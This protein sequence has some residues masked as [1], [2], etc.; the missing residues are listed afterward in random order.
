MATKGRM[1]LIITTADVLRGA[2]SIEIEF[3]CGHRSLCTVSGVESARNF[4]LLCGWRPPAG[5][6]LPLDRLTADAMACVEGYQISQHASAQVEAPGDAPRTDPRS[7]APAASP[8]R[9]PAT[10]AP[11]SPCCPTPNPQLSTLNPQLS[12]STAAPSPAAGIPWGLIL[13]AA[14]TATGVGLPVWAVMAMRGARRVKRLRAAAKH[15][16]QPNQPAGNVTTQRVVDAPAP[17]GSPAVEFPASPARDT[18]EAREFLQLSRLEGRDP[19]HD[20][21]VGRFA[22][23]ELDAIIDRDGPDG[24]WATKLRK[25]IVDRFNEMVPFKLEPQHT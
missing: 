10:S 22:L 6:P 18:R 3:E 11:A 25:T 24:K 14:G 21:L 12:T 19:L 13:A 5:R 8:A 17:K 23:D 16:E 7:V 1:A 4:G 20:A 15:C 2:Q 9:T